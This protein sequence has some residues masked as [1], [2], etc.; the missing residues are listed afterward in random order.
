MILLRSSSV[1]FG[2]ASSAMKMKY[3]A[4]YRRSKSWDEPR[5][6]DMCAPHAIGRE[7]LSTQQCPWCA[8]LGRHPPPPST[9]RPL[10]GSPHSTSM[11]RDS[12]YFLRTVFAHVVGHTGIPRHASYLA[13]LQTGLEYGPTKRQPMIDSHIGP[14]T[15]GQLPPLTTFCHNTGRRKAKTI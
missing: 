6:A 8:S 14:G 10:D 12:P 9:P 5:P 4:G 15:C 13:R 2:I 7:A 3:M 11:I 1:L